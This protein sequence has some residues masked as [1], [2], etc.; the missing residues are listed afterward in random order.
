YG[1][2]GNRE[3]W[4]D[5]VLD[6]VAYVNDLE[7]EKD[8]RQLTDKNIQT[9]SNQ[10]VN[11]IHTNPNMT[12]IGVVFCTSKWSIINDQISI[13]CQS[14]QM[15]PYNKKVVM[16]TIFYN[17]TLFYRSPYLSGFGKNLQKD[18]VLLRLK[19]SIDNAIIDF[20]SKY[21]I[22]VASQILDLEN[23]NNQSILDIDFKERIENV[24]Q[25][26]PFAYNR[27]TTG[28]DV[29]TTNGAFYFFIP[30]MI[31]FIIL[32]NEILRE[33]QK[34]LRH[35][36]FFFFYILFKKGI[37]VMGMSHFSYWLSWNITG[38]ILNGITCFIQVCSGI[39]FRF[40]IFIKTPFLIMFA[41][42]WIFSLSI[43]QISFLITNI[44][45]DT[46]NGYSVAYGF[47]LMSIV[48]EFFLTNNFFVYYLY[49]ED[50]DFFI[51]FLKNAFITYPAYHYSKIFG[52]IA[53]KSGKH[54][55]V[56][57]SRWI[58][59]KEYTYQDLFEPIAGKFTLPKESSYE[60]PSTFQ[61]FFHLF[62][63][64]CIYFWLS[65]YSDHV[66]PNV[67]QISIFL[68]NYVLFL[69]R[70]GVLQNNLYFLFHLN[71]GIMSQD[72]K[73]ANTVK[74]EKRRVKANLNGKAETKGIRIIKMGKTYHKYPFG[75]K[76]SKDKVALNKIYL[77]IEGGELLA[78]LGHN[79][80]GKSTLI[81]ILTGLLSPTSG[82]AEMM[83][84][85]INTEMKEI[86][87][88]MGVCP[89]FDILWDELTA[90]EHLYLFSLLKG[91]PQNQVQTQIK[92]S[93]QQVSLLNV[94][95]A[96]VGTYSGGM[97]RRV[98]LAI[99]AIGNPKIIFMDEP[100]TGMDPKTR[101]EIWEM[102]RNLKK[103]KVVVL[104][105]HAMEEAEVLADRI[106]VVAG[107]ELKCIGTPLYLKNHYSDGYRLNL[108]TD[109]QNV[110]YARIAI[111]Q[112]IPSCKIL[113]EK[114]GNIIACVPV[115]HLNELGNFFKI[116]ENEA[117]DKSIYN[118][119]NIIKDWGLSHSTIE[120]VFMKITK[121]KKYLL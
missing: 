63:T 113:D 28:Y 57:E 27:F 117:T 100:T 46:A 76:T 20:F 98:S 115:I 118:L 21:D 39:L 74:R 50:A 87:S 53:F 70:I 92:N 19:T 75:I 47:L 43:T 68:F 37:M 44:C 17:W 104:T 72:L 97:K 16:Y 81:N 99:S 5:Y 71:I 112:A 88:I 96:Q 54:Y 30:I 103:D 45:T 26:F 18:W 101:R 55:S 59:G 78:I 49:R 69:I 108:V 34:K 73:K 121:A 48:L 14:N 24:A 95:R 32:I 58:D 61:S 56:Q 114:G 109:Q 25:D 42:L 29:V 10:F 65:V 2:I 90:E 7:L 13:P 107:G 94:M 52:D 40:D 66:F 31:N 85:D 22:Q 9:N 8:I 3:K 62:L 4:I 82:T 23:Q 120:E 64:I 106:V 12:Q 1:I 41:F 105:T 79:G 33:K 83:G 93:L 86:Q 102:I 60:C 80:A 35:G 116:M 67:K 51:I 111:K 36:N 91:V 89:Q 6:Y 38:G 15:P 84:Y 11:F 110:D 77:E 119:K